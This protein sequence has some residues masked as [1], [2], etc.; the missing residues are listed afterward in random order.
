MKL[1]FMLFFLLCIHYANAQV[2]YTQNFDVNNG[3]YTTLNGYFNLYTNTTTCIGTGSGVRANLYSFQTSDILASPT[4]G[5]SLGNSTT[6]TY[7]YK[8]AN[9]SANTTGTTNPWGSFLVQWSNTSTGPWTTI[10]TVDQSNHTVSGSCVTK[11]VTFTPTSGSLFIRFNATWTAGDYYLNYDDITITEVTLP[12]TASAGTITATNTGSLCAPASTTLSLTGA[13]I[14]TGISYQWQTS[15]D[16]ATFTDSAGATAAT[17]AVTGLSTSRYYKCKVSC[18][19]T[20]TILTTTSYQVIITPP[21]TI[22]V[23]P[24]GPVFLCNPA[25]Q[26]LTVSTTATTP[27]YQWKYNGVNVGT[28]SATYTASQ[29]GTYTV[30]ITSGAC[31]TPS[32]NVVVNISAGANTPTGTNYTIC[33]NETIQSGTGIAAVA[34]GVNT[35]PNLTGTLAGPATYNRSVVGTS[36]VASGVGTTVFYNTITFKVTTTGSYTFNQCAPTFDGFG[37]LHTSTFN[38]ASPAT[39]FLIANDDT[40]GNPNCSTGT[41][42]GDDARIIFSLTAGIDYVLVTSSF[43]IG[44]T[45]YFEWTYNGPGTLVGQASATPT[46]NWFTAATGGSSFGSGSP[47]NPVGVAGSGLA[48]SSNSGTFTF[49]AEANNGCVSPSRTPVN[50]IITNSTST[51]GLAAVNAGTQVCKTAAVNTSG[52][53]YFDNNCNL[54]ATVIPTGATPVTGNIK[55]CV[56]IESGVLIDDP[57]DNHPYVQRHYD[58]EPTTNA[59]NATAVVKLYFLQSEFDAYNNYVIANGNLYPLLPT[60]TIDNGNARITQFHGV[61]TLP[62]NYLPRNIAFS[63]PILTWDATNNWWEV[64]VPVLGFSGFYL[65]TGSQSLLAVTNSIAINATNTGATNTIYWSMPTQTGIA[66]YE[67]QKS[68]DGANFTTFEIVN[69]TNTTNYTAID[70]QP[71]ATKQ[72]YRIKAIYSNNSIQYSPNVTLKRNNTTFEIVDIR[73]NPTK[74]LMYF[75][76]IG[77]N[78][79]IVVNITDAQGKII[80]IKNYNQSQQYQLNMSTYSNGMYF[81]TITLL[82]TGAKQIIKIIKN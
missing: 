58:I 74:D 68:N 21:P 59:A 19:A 43:D 70:N 64:S 45:G 37:T 66:K 57:T 11:S 22:T 35:V 79:N 29:N 7:K 6:F 25:S 8:V 27:T 60:L 65:H 15:P 28:N 51:D 48:N 81:A 82:K 53:Q 56:V 18:S 36:Y 75:K 39:N 14:G 52:T 73:P 16:N 20:A 34:T 54:I 12:C 9:W 47:F 69:T 55:T 2:N 1:I 46:I 76:A 30:H 23:S 62:I 41:N 24:S 42:S 31:T 63:V 72:W 67:V 40:N 61:G 13:G 50:L 49:Y 32:A 33:K 77:N 4:V 5:T 17:L 3:G 78:G 38:P 44:E 10:Q 80:E 26:M 71:N